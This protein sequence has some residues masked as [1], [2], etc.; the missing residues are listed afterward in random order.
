MTN[1]RPID[2][3]IKTQRATFV[4]RGEFDSYHHIWWHRHVGFIVTGP[5]GRDFNGRE[6]IFNGIPLITPQDIA[7]ATI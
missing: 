4:K 6:V 1:L 3:R 2:P 5:D 7:N